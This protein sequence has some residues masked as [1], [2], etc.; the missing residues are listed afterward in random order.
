[1]DGKQVQRWANAFGTRLERD[2]DAEV[3]A[4]ESGIR[5]APPAN[6]AE[7]LV[8]GPDGGRVQMRDPDPESG[9]RWR[10]DKVFTVT[11][12]VPGDGKERKPEPLVTT[13]VASMEKTEMFGRLARVEG[14][15]RGWRQA[16]QVIAIADCGNWIDP[17]LER[18]FPGAVRIA[19]W[20]HVEERLHDCA[21]A[22]YGKDTPQAKSQVGQWLSL[23]AAGRAADVLARLKVKA[24]RLGSPCATDKEDHPRRI[25][26]QAVGFFEKNQGHMKYPEYRRKGWPIGSGNTEAGVKQFNKRVKGSERFWGEAGIEAI[27]CLRALRLSQDGRWDRYWSNRPAYLRQT[28]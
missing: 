13:H 26:S 16:E 24:Q 27:L 19:D 14:E 11:S 20:F 2:R 9:S 25:L 23:L 12:Y 7:L 17:L 8:I 18:E 22:A 28:A 6:P 10:E 1:L 5:P 15:R 21:K 3:L 4:S